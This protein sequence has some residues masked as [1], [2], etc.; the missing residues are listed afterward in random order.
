[1]DTEKPAARYLAGR[2]CVVGLCRD[3]YRNYYQGSGLVYLSS[4]VDQ[5]WQ[6]IYRWLE[7]HPT[8]QTL[9]PHIQAKAD[10]VNRHEQAGFA[11]VPLPGMDRYQVEEVHQ[12]IEEHVSD[13]AARREAEHQLA[14][15]IHEVADLRNRPDFH[16]IANR[17]SSCRMSG[18]AGKASDDSLRI[19]WDYKCGL[20]RLCPDEAREEQQRLTDFY[21][22]DMLEFAKHPTHRIFYCVPTTHNYRPTDL[23][24]GKHEMFDMFSEFY[25]SFDQIKGAFVIQED[26]LSAHMDWNVHLNAFLLVQG[27]FDYKKVREQWGANIWIRELGKDE[28]SLR[29]ALM[30]ALKYSARIVPEKSADKNKDTDAPSMVEWPAV[31]FEEWLD[32]QRRPTPD[33]IVSF[34]RT[35]AYGVLYALH[36]KRWNQAT[37]KKRMQWCD[38]AGLKKH[39]AASEWVDIGKP[40]DLKKK[41]REKLK[42][43]LRKVMQNGPPEEYGVNQWLAVVSFTPGQGYRVSSIPGDNF[44]GVPR[45]KRQVFNDRGGTG[46]P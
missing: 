6:E 27:E 43:K 4:V 36:R 17:L 12:L 11:Q 2:L 37:I 25:K 3:A 35:R 30:E 14:D 40:E 7:N 19:L 28:Q 42:I 24:R 44:S 13:Y 32:A 41:D 46:P 31:L 18:V 34:R 39:H 10:L 8:A 21:L 23:L 16:S 33:R 26:P 9:P 45:E 38:W 15:Y 1:M 5:A 22:P 29:S 20:V